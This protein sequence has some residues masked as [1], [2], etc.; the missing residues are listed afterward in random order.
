M[1][2]SCLKGDQKLAKEFLYNCLSNFDNKERVKNDFDEKMVKILT[3][4]IGRDIPTLIIPY[5]DTEFI[6][7][8]SEN[9]MFLLEGAAGSGKSFCISEFIKENEEKD[10]NFIV[11]S[12]THKAKSIVIK[13]MM[14]KDCYSAEFTT[15]ASL[16][17]M[18][19]VYDKSGN[20]EFMCMSKRQNIDDDSK[21]VVFV[22]ESSMLSRH[23]YDEFKTMMD[24][25]KNTVTVFVGDNCQLPPVNEKDSIVFHKNFPTFSLL[26]K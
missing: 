22:D 11:S 6:L 14:N 5:L 13:E 24:K 25:K 17:Q 20:F 18:S 19:K 3:T 2:I 16:L 8:N 10:I 21:C 23:D 1:N 4:I 15:V 7:E 26:G 12:P 9:R